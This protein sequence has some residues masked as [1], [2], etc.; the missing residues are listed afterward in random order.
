MAVVF[1]PFQLHRFLPAG[2][3]IPG[4]LMLILAFTLSSQTFAMHVKGGYIQYIYNGAGATSGT[5]SYTITVTVFFSCTAAGPR[6]SVY[7]GIFNASTDALVASQDI[8]TT[9]S[10]T[11]TK[12]TYSPCMSDPPT[13]CYEIYTYVY[14]VDLADIS[15]GYVLAIQD[16]Y[17]TDGII[18]ISNSGSDG[19]T[20][21]A[22]I[23]GTISGIDYHANSSPS[24][25]FKDTAIICYD[26]SFTYPFSATDPDG[27]S[28][29]YAFGD[30]LNVS[31]ASAN[32]SGSVPA[33]PPYTS[34]TYLTGY[35]G[36]LPLGSG[37]TI[38]AV[39]GLISGTAPAT[40]GEYVVAVYVSEWR[41]GVK[42]N[43]TKKELQVYVY[44]CSLA[45][46]TLNTSY[47][48]CGNYTFTFE[49]ETTASNITSYYWTFG[50]GATSTSADPTYTYPDTG[51]YKLTLTVSN[52]SGCTDTTSSLVKVYPGF[53][54]N[55]TYTGNCYLSPFQFTDATV[56]KYGSV[57]SW[58][59]AFGDASTSTAQDPSHTYSAAGTETVQLIVGS[60]KGCLDTV[61]KSVTVFGTPDFSLPTTD[62]LIC[63]I[64]SLPL[65][66]NGVGTGLT[67]S[68]SPN[69]N[70][71]DANTDSAVVWPKDTTVY[72]VT[73]TQNGCSA[74]A[75]ETVNVLDYITVTLPADTTICKTDSIKL[76]PVSYALR[77]AWT[78]G[79]SLSDSTTKYPEA[80]PDTNTTYY[81]TANLGKCQAK[82]SEYVKV[83]AYPQ[84][85]VTGDTTI[86]Y[87]SSAQLKGTI[88][89]AYYTWTPDSSLLDANTLQP[90]ADPLQTTWYVLTV[91]DTLG[92]PKKVSD[93]ALVAVIPQVVVFAGNDTSVVVG[94]PL[95]L[96]GVSTD[97]ALV[98]WSW[99]P[100]TW[101]NNAAI[102][103][104]VA[105]I[106][107]A[108]DSITYTATATT[109]QGC[110][111]NAKL[112]V[113]VY[114]TLPDIFMPNA[115]T[116]NGD[117][118]NDIFRPILVGIS[119]LDF[120]RIFNRWGQMVY[121]TTQNGQ[122]WDGT[123]GGRP[124][125]T[126]TFVYMVQGKDYTGKIHFKKGT[127]I[128]IR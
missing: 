44:S 20:I 117:G 8:S 64:D 6:A 116:P 67:Y 57:N 63:S 4:L 74:T 112:T 120:F 29:S 91:S 90:V 72:T 113:T 104:P 53:T 88:V 93:S 89:A 43:T 65:L 24:F 76:D 58:N 97:S 107:S 7:L 82:S 15:A 55:F 87:G 5:S 3:K 52:S 60:N 32:T 2:K 81:L 123:L 99:T 51:T 33:S 128:L 85:T 108:I 114:T 38:N 110:Y 115:F 96:N 14:T 78:P 9:T 48:N 47:V 10:A 11:V 69:Y 46:A 102:Y 83:V 127:F 45:A 25:I 71:L 26:G 109:S 61:S 100:D 66:V 40:T 86:C 84:V 92:C 22:T 95:Q 125:E 80:A 42:I 103:D 13:I 1:R 36:A 126:G 79:S 27:D 56:A 16:A 54:P 121:A 31:S 70:I 49:N 68:W 37:V 111:G 18:N 23:P 77:Y 19:I 34:L 39:T 59:W 124:Q 98:T 50:N 35:S 62:T 101:L 119:N 106:T 17:R 28:L 30:G 41:R 12:T 94:E 73:V 75:S 21:N 105:T 118:R 122:G